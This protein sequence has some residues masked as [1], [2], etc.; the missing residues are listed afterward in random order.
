MSNAQSEGGPLHNLAAFTGKSVAHYE[1]LLEAM[2]DEDRTEF[3]PRAVA[4]ESGLSLAVVRALLAARESP[5][6]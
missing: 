4:H 2:R 1:E 3:F 6:Q 5:I